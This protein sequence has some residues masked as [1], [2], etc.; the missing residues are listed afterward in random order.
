MKRSR[1]F[2]RWLLVANLGLAMGVIVLSSGRHKPPV[3]KADTGAAEAS[4]PAATETDAAPQ[5]IVVTNQ[6]QWAQLESEDYR[7]YIKRLRAIGCPEQ[8]IRDL[9]IADLDKL[10]A[11]KVQAIYGR[12]PQVH[13]WDSEEE[14]LAN[15]QDH[16][17]WARKEREIDREKRE[18]VQELLGT[19]L[20]RERL[21]VKG[22]QDYYERRLAFL[23]EDKRDAVRGVLDQYETAARTAERGATK[24]AAQARRPAPGRPGQSALPGRAGAI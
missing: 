8:T 15:N 18:I 6:L 5:T 4:E 17:E 3:A 2:N 1:V 20:V 14:E 23:P 11:P 21:K 10:L 13:Y 22:Q 7:T 24:R 9:I 19:D 16:R 12:R